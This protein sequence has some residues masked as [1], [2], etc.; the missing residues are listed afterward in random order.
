M[1]K[2]TYKAK[3]AP[4][5]MKH[6][7][8]LK[9]KK[10]KDLTAYQKLAIGSW[11]N[12]KDPSIYGQSDI[13][14]EKA[15][16]FTEKTLREK[17]I[18]LTP[19]YLIAQAVSL[20]FSAHPKLNTLL[21]AGVL[22]QRETI[23]FSFLVSIGDS[24]SGCVVRD[25]TQLDIFRLYQVL[26]KKIEQTKQEKDETVK[27]QNRLISKIPTPLM[28]YFLD[29]S[30]F[31]LYTLNIRFKGLP[32]DPF[33]SVMI[34]NLGQMGI[35]N[36]FIP[37]VPYARI[38]TIIAI[39]LVKPRPVV[40][41]E[42]TVTVKNILRLNYTIDHRHI[43]GKSLALMEKMLFFA[44]KDPNKWLRPAPATVKEEFKREFYQSLS[45]PSELKQENTAN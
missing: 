20:V 14:Y 36:A 9:L 42:K 18:K 41:K 30:S 32:E 28:R 45:H 1:D 43:E 35:D 44:F 13:D 38:P 31:L 2:R 4:Y 40:T 17:N 15:G 10:I 27:T 22:Y 37:L 29:F 26:R 11:R 25:I 24:L 5:N 16:E 33:G 8:H 7:K 6:M 23:T 39:G 3:S 21:R 34:S 12:A 19:T